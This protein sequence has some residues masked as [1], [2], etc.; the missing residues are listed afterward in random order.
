MKLYANYQNAKGIPSEVCA[1]ALIF[2]QLPCVLWA[3]VRHAAVFNILSPD[4]TE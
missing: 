1:A 3:L 4:F 2:L